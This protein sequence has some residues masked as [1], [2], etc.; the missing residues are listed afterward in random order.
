MDEDEIKAQVDTKKIN[1]HTGGHSKML[2][3]PN[4]GL[5]TY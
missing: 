5:D 4:D 3:L 1:D 2:L